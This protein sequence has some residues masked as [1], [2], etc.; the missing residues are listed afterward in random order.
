[1]PL[2]LELVVEM[3]QFW[4]THKNPKLLFPARPRGSERDP[5]VQA[6]LKETLRPMEASAV[7]EA[8]RQA[9]LDAGVRTP[10]TP[11]TLRHS[12]ATHLLEDGVSLRQISAYLGHE[13]LDTTAIYC[14]LTVVSE[15]RTQAVLAGLYQPPKTPPTA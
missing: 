13:S 12:Y 11:H 6:T 9:R 2:L 14:H 10:A 5:Q 1:V 15:A 8:F 4:L 3:R 7:Q